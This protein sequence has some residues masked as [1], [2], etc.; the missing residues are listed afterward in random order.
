MKSIR[1]ICVSV[2][3]LAL[4]FLGSV[5]ETD[6]QNIFRTCAGTSLPRVSKFELEKTGNVLINPCFGKVIKVNGVTLSTAGGTAFVLNG[7]TSFTQSFAVGIADAP[8]IVSDGSLHTF[9]FPISSLSG[10]GRTNYAPYFTGQNA[11]GK[12]SLFFSGGNATFENNLTVNGQLKLSP[13]C[14]GT[15]QID[16]TN[17]IT[18]SS[19]CVSASSKIF[20]NYQSIDGAATTGVLYNVGRAPGTSFSFAST[21]ANDNNVISYLIIN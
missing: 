17:P 10:T 12:S 6:A 14:S 7:L 8:G 1:F 16:G 2:F 5:F 3:F 11:L 4:C 9:N 18:V 19:N 13:A 20:L 15:L 21:N